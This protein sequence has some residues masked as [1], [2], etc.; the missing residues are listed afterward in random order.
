MSGICSDGREQLRTA[1]AVGT[2]PCSASRVDCLTCAGPL[3]RAVVKWLRTQGVTFD[4]QKLHLSLVDHLGGV[5]LSL[6]GQV[7]GLTNIQVMRVGAIY[8]TARATDVRIV[9][10]LRPLR[11][12]VVAAHELGHVW[13]ANQK[14]LSVPS[15]CSEG[16][17]E[18]VAYRF[19]QSVGSWEARLEAAR[20]RA[21]PEPTYGGGFRRLKGFCTRVGFP[22]LCEA[23]KTNRLSLI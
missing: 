3:F 22:N 6:P 17:C 14:V 13:L 12:Q 2:P 7:V 4:Q 8:L 20:I 11:F 19:A 10:D 5:S 15:W 23:L 18:L 21:N 16:F 9:R 1:A